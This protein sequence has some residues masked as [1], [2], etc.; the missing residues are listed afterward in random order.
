MMNKQPRL[1]PTT[2]SRLFQAGYDSAIRG[3]LRA[4]CQDPIYMAAIAE[5]PNIPNGIAYA[6]EWQRGYQCQVD[7]ACNRIFSV[8]P[9]K[10]WYVP[11]TIKNLKA[12]LE[13][14][15][16]IIQSLIFDRDLTQED[17]ESETQWANHYFELSKKNETGKE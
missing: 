13:R 6:D 4:P 8:P 14:S 5:M 3:D 17:L 1:S 9:I 15:S 16:L 7:E 2:L 11:L 10:W 12:A